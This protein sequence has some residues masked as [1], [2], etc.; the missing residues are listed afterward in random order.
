MLNTDNTYTRILTIAG[1]DS[2]GGA[3]I[4]ADLKTITVLGGYGMSVIT[5]ITAQ[6]TKG[7]SAIYPVPLNGITSQLDAV[8]SD[9]GADAV[10]I[11]M[12]FSPEVIFSVAQKLKEYQIKKIV[13]DPV[14][15][16]T[17]GDRLL[18]MEAIDALK[19]E[20]FPIA[21]LI[22]PNIPEAAMLIDKKIANLSDME[23]QITRLTQ[24][25]S[26]AVLLK[27]GHLDAEV[28]TD[29]LYIP[30]SYQIFEFSNPKISTTNTHGTGCTL[31]SAVATY[32]GMGNDLFSSVESAIQ[33]L[34]NAIVAGKDIKTGKGKG[35]VFHN[36]RTNQE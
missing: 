6:N 35:P 20:L 3:G 4:Q 13:V 16:A 11:G 12:L 7:V 30:D 27:G 5:A 9:I 2:G 21:S 19:K 32:L 18:K 26:T 10:K 14:M 15:V 24:W 25:G 34:H 1:S 17:S 33:Y 31:S 36:F 22:T 23:L 28:C 8:L 29:L